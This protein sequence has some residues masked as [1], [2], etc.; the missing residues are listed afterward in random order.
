MSKT[1]LLEVQTNLGENGMLLC[2]YTESDEL[3]NPQTLLPSTRVHPA[4]R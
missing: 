4:S 3:A 1:S 2:N